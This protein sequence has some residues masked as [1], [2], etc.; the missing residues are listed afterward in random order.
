MEPWMIWAIAVIVLITLEMFTTSFF[1]A[2]LAVGAL[3]SAVVAAFDLGLAWQFLFFAAGSILAF[4]FVRPFMMK[5]FIKKDKVKTGVD[6]L[7][8]RTGRVSEAIDPGMSRG[9][10]AV[11]GDDWKAVSVDNEA[12]PFGQSVEIVRVDSTILYVRKV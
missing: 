6:A 11:D 4:I 5:Y 8:G 2:C 9:R 1:S 12:I 3:C 7:V 10:V